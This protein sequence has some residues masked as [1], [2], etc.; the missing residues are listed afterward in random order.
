MLASIEKVENGYIA[1]FERHLKHSVET[2]WSWLTENEKLAQWFSELRVDE[3]SKGGFYKFD[4]Q[5]GSFEELE[6]IEF[7]MY[8]ILEFM[9]SGEDSV[10]F[11]LYQESG[12][13]K[14]VL[15]E[16]IEVITDHTPKDLAGWH[17]CL[18][19][20]NALMDGKTIDFREDDWKE[21]NE[22]YILAVKK[23]TENNK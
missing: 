16:K 17:V 18:D 21:W 19:V 13:C 5:D 15:K 23:A 6:I 22:K 7:K 4:M 11:E 9:W 14:L 20:I 3:L 10:R 1:R 8:D 2:V 12:G